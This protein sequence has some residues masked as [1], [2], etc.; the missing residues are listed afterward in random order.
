MTSR[1][2]HILMLVSAIL[3]FVPVFAVDYILDGY[4]RMRETASMQ[5]LLDEIMVET[6]DSVYDGIKIIRTVVDE[7]PSL[8]T[9][10]FVRNAQNA[11]SV[12]LSF[13]Q[14]LV[15][16]ADGVQ[17]CDLFG[18]EVD[19]S[20][21]SQT[22]G[23]P[24]R[25]ETLTVV[26]LQGYDLPLLKVSRL[27]GVKRVSAFVYLSP[28][29]AHGMPLGF[30]DATTFRIALTNGTPI[31][32]YG[33]Y[34]TFASRT[35]GMA[36]I[37]V[38]SFASEIPIRSEVAVPFIDVRAGYSDLDWAFTI[39]ACMMSGGFLILA[40]Q[41]VR[42]SALPAM[43]IER[44]IVL[45]E[46]KPFYQP[47]IDLGTGRLLGCEVLVRWVKRN[48]EIVTPNSFI[49]YAEVSGMAIPMTVH[50][51]QIARVDLAE[52]MAEMPELKISINLFEGHFRDGS[53]VEDVQAIFEGSPI[54]YRQLVFEI[55]ERRPLA[56]SIQAASVIA[57]LHALGARLALDDVG[58]GHSNLAYMQTLGV[59]VIKIDQVF[60]RMIQ[61]DTTRLPVLDGL[62]EMARDLGADI[63]AEGVETEA[64]A[65]YLRE[66]GVMQAQGYLFAPALKAE[67]FR[68]L[69]R[70]LN[71]A[72][73]DSESE[74]A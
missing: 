36:F 1:Y 8:C 65:I 15:E 28:R 13:R 14:I 21:L 74:A 63:V 51:M 43:D 17:Y 24:G 12:S 22:L 37:A 38:N 40:L 9:P 34:D 64:Q 59:D 45:G 7:S 39:F 19:Y 56:N 58:T 66:H 2:S 54:R 33:N 30:R 52:L 49:E 11:V 55:T 35:N 73:V 62:I 25:P 67:T 50:L 10:T 5:Q 41:Y 47:V 42:R 70:A 18:Q 20:V 3:A 57:G 29:L 32:T 16:N 44:A 4:I 69:A 27:V 60:V 68:T 26:R 61:P 31:V 6:E 72:A 48:G 23:L 53:I 46:L 71:F